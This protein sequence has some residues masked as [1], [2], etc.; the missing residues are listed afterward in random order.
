MP[1]D[2]E[3]SFGIFPKA[4]GV[5]EKRA[6]VLANNLANQDTPGFKAQ[7]IDFRGALE[8]VL[9]EKDASKPNHPKAALNTDEQTLMADFVKYRTAYQPSLDG[10]TVDG[11][12]EQS[13]FADNTLRYLASLRFLSGKIEGIKM[14][15][16]GTK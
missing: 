11:Q 12:I 8:R 15:I 6:Q 13:E 2:L 4:L 10:N 14:A 16:K 3:S 7:D 1:F 9:A 5:F